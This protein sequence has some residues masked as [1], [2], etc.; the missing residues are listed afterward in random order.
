MRATAL[1]NGFGDLSPA[2]EAQILKEQLI[3]TYLQ[4]AGALSMVTLAILAVCNAAREL[5]KGR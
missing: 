3:Q 5:R 2:A 1:H 4:A